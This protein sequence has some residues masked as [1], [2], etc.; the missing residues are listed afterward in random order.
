MVLNRIRMGLSRLPA[1][2]TA[3]LAVISCSMVNAQT[4]THSA[5]QTVTAANSISC[6]ANGIHADNSYWRSF[7]LCNPF[8]ISSEVTI[9]A[10]EFGN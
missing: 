7:D 10:I 9:T 1:L 3:M 2:L 4:M 5:T 6:N 8:N